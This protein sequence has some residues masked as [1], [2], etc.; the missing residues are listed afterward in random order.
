MNTIDQI[1]IVAVIV[2]LVWLFVTKWVTVQTHVLP[3]KHSGKQRKGKW[4][5]QNARL[6]VAT[7]LPRSPQWTVGR[8]LKAGGALWR[9]TIALLTPTP[10][11]SHLTVSEITGKNPRINFRGFYF[12]CVAYYKANYARAASALV[13]I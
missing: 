11:R 6:R 2:L 9:D 13:T 3:G 1:G 7:R 4:Q 8:S 5:S 12:A 10:L